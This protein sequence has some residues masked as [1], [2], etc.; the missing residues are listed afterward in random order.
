MRPPAPASA[1]ETEVAAASARVAIAER[2]LEELELGQVDAGTDASV[3]E[4]GSVRDR[5][6]GRRERGEVLAG[7]VVR[8]E[9]AER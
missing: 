6:S 8:A 3:S 2:V 5:A 4:V 9:G 7:G 1:P